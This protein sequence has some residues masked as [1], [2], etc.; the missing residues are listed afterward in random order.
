MTS[1]GAACAPDSAPGSAPQL[2]YRDRDGC[3]VRMVRVGPSLVMVEEQQGG[4]GVRRSPPIGEVAIP[5]GRGHVPPDVDVLLLPCGWTSPLPG[6]AG[7]PDLV[8]R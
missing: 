8:A 7:L 1:R 5:L 3:E 2:R 6:G 4:R